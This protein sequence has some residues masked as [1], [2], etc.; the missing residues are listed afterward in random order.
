MKTPV[1]KKNTVIMHFIYITTLLDA[2]YENLQE[3]L[4]W[5]QSALEYVFVP[6]EVSLYTLTQIHTFPT[7]GNVQLILY[8][9][10]GIRWIRGTTQSPLKTLT[11]ET[12]IRSNTELNGTCSWA[13]IPN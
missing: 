11:S 1:E 9:M 2:F 5:Q 8:V 12:K 3:I 7:M 10:T 6:Q 13:K 4:V